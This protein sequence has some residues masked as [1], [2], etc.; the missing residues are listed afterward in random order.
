MA[1]IADINEYVSALKIPRAGKTG[2][3]HFG[4]FDIETQRSAKE[5]GGWHRADRMRVSCV[6][7]YDSKF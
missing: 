5:V 2:G 3:G 6:I 1:S 7:V 4:V